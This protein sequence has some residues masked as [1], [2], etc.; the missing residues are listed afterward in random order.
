MLGKGAA[1]GATDV[2]AFMTVDLHV[3]V[4]PDLEEVLL[5]PREVVPERGGLSDLDL[6]R[7]PLI[8]VLQLKTNRVGAKLQYSYN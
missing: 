3:A 7:G 5:P 2:V 6:R 4:D 1:G 8:D